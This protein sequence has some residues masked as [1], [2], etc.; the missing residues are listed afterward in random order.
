[1]INL[2]FLKAAVWLC[3]TRYLGRWLNLT[4]RRFVY[5]H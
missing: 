3:L 4:K 5:D 1:L 2:K